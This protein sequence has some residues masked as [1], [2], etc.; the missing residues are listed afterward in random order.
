MLQKLFIVFHILTAQ[1][2]ILCYAYVK[3]MWLF[4]LKKTVIRRYSGT[5]IGQLY[6]KQD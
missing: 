5:S 3:W 2:Q 6:E 1:K 4:T